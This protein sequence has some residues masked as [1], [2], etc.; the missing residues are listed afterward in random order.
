M[1]RPRPMVGVLCTAGVLIGVAL[2]WAG[3]ISAAAFDILFALAMGNTV[4]VL[5]PMIGVA[6][7]RAARLA[8]MVAAVA[9]AAV[10]AIPPV[11][12]APYLAI[13]LINAFVAYVFGR[14][15]MTGGTPL[16][17]QMIRVTQSGPECT[18]A[19]E[20]YVRGQCWCWAV[21]GSVTALC[22]LAAMLFPAARPVLNP[23]L[24]GL[25]A[26][27]I[28]WFPLAHY[29]A[30]LRYKRPETWMGTARHMS[31]PETWAGLEI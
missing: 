11:Q 8:I 26:L 19:F 2:L 20:R 21:F 23:V 24:S 25:F 31:R 22:G 10:V 6:R 5:L 17:V 9:I 14:G 12:L 18:T 16:I 7:A 4:F 3:V 13:V 15:V 1:S 28:V 29:Y 27:Q 30:R